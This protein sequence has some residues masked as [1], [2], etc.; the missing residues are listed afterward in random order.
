VVLQGTSKATYVKII[1]Q[2]ALKADNRWGV[3]S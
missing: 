1:A 2:D 3:R